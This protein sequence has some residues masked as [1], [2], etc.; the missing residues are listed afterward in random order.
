MLNKIKTHKIVTAIIL[1][2]LVLVVVRFATNLSEEGTGDRSMA[3]RAVYVELGQ[4][5]LGTMREVGQ[6]YGSLIAAH[7]FQVSPKVGG[8]LKNLLV[9]IGDKIESGQLLAGLDDHQYRL[10]KEQATYNVALAEAQLAEAQANLALAQNDMTRQQSL[11]E[12]SIITQ[13]DFEATENRLSQAEARQ[14]V[15]V[16]QLSGARSQLEDAELR[17]SYTQINAVWPEGGSR[18]VGERLVSEGDL[19]TANTPILTIVGLDQ[20]LVVVEV[21]EK[22]YPKI[23]VGQEAEL[24]TEAWPGEVFTGRVV[25]VAPILS[26]STRQARVELEVENKDLRLKPGMFAE[27]IFIFQEFKNVWSVPQ[28]L[29]FRR[30][31]GFVIFVADEANSTVKMQPVTLGLVEDGWVELV[32]SP[33]LAAPV[34]FLGQ[35]LLDDGFIYREPGVEAKKSNKPEGKKPEGKKSADETPVKES[36][37]KS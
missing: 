32:G 20:L 21:I 8:E 25:R 34:V 17:L 15:A 29:P 3:Q 35:H 36:G 13:S 14:G 28:D 31:E 11:S 7:K 16:S 19:L 10:A 37:V 23:R 5:R 1:V 12:K 9:D 30:Q 22:D 27:V 33:P 4:A 24:L 6:Y 26:A 18:W 2:F